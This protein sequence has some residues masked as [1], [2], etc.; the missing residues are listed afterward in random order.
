MLETV[1]AQGFT[2]IPP[3]RRTQINKRSHGAERALMQ[4]TQRG[5]TELK[6]RTN[7]LADY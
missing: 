3:R 5:A 1:M 4:C 2:T 7:E 6:K